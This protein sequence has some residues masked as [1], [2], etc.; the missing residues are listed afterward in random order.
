MRGN[1]HHEDSTM[2]LEPESSGNTCP[3]ANHPPDAG[4]G[5]LPERDTRREIF[6][7]RPFPQCSCEGIGTIGDRCI[8]AWISQHERYVGGNSYGCPFLFLWRGCSPVHANIDEP[9]D[10]QGGNA[11]VL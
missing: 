7:H 9:R 5:A 4:D 3:P 10:E 6:L 2:V 8:A 11:G 1:L